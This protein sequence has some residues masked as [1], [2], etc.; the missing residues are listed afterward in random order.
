M[1]S[2]SGSTLDYARNDGQACRL[3]ARATQLFN[4][5]RTSFLANAAVNAIP[6]DKSDSPRLHRD[7]AAVAITG[8][9][10]PSEATVQRLSDYCASLGVKEPVWP[11][12]L[13]GS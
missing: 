3:L 8:L 9:N 6:G 4:S 2:C 10:N 7:V 1:A 5:G 12:S 11:Q 13:T